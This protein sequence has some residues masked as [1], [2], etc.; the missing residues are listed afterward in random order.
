M[1][2]HAPSPGAVD[3]LW[4]LAYRAA[5]QSLRLWWLVRRPPAEGAAVALW[6]KDHLLLVRPSYRPWLDLPGGGVGRHEEEGEGACRELREETGIVAPRHA[7]GQPVELHFLQDGR[8]VRSNVFPWRPTKA[9][10]PR[11]DGREILWTGYRHP[12]EIADLPMSP[13]LRLYLES[14]STPT[15]TRNPALS[16]AG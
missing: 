10:V 11:A 13:C 9:P 2:E 15:P 16:D 1:A 6:A 4:R 5:F 14:L 7:L 8:R 3:Q 12:Q